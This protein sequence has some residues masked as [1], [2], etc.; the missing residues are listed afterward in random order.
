MPVGALIS[1]EEYLRTSYSPDRDYVDGEVLERNLGGLDHSSTQ[2]EVLFYLQTRYPNLRKRLLSEQRVQ[3]R[4]DRFRVPDICLLAE[5]APREQIVR[6]PPYLCI[7]ILSPEDTMTRTIRRIKDYLDMGVPTCWIL[8]PNTRAAWV[9]TP[10]HLAEA[11]DGI[12]RAGAL[13]MP[14]VEVLD[15]IPKSPL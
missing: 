10:G 11:Q 3:V 12:L 15:Q 4:A 14:L 2:R 6:T 1:V 5:G 13:E 9:A 7:E 8:D